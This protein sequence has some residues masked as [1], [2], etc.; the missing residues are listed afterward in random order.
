[1]A[2]SDLIKESHGVARVPP[3]EQDRR[4]AATL[5]RQIGQVDGLLVELEQLPAI[6]ADESSRAKL[7]EINK[8]LP[9]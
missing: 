4:D 2:I 6:S 8:R 7:E 5:Q 3:A 9:N 1:M